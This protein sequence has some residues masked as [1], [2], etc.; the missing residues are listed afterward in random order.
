MKKIVSSISIEISKIDCNGVVCNST[1]HLH[2]V[3]WLPPVFIKVIHTYCKY[4]LIQQLQTVCSSQ[5]CGIQ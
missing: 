4:M 2:T 5:Y 3:Y 1:G